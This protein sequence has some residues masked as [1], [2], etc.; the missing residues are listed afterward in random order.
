[1]LSVAFLYSECKSTAQIATSDREAPKEKI[2]MD[3]KKVLQQFEQEVDQYIQ[4]LEPYSIEQ[5]TLQPEAEQWSLGQMY[6]HLIQSAQQM[7]LANIDTCIKRQQA[8][9][10]I[11]E[12]NYKTYAGEAILELGNFPPIRVQVPASP[13]YTPTQPSTKAELLEGLEQVRARMQNIEPLLATVNP[14]YTVAHPRF[15]HLNAQEWF[16]II[17]MH[18]RHHWLQKNRLDQFLGMTV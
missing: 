3:T 18:Y 6:N 9:E 8:E 15:G 4:A 14:Q 1:M 7:H 5:L 13:F 11:T 16:T 17:D 2:L 10:E 12:V